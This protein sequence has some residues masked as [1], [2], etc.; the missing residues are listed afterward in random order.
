MKCVTPMLPEPTHT[1]LRCP[2]RASGAVEG[3]LLRPPGW[4][5]EALKRLLTI[6]PGPKAVTVQRREHSYFRGDAMADAASVAAVVTRPPIPAVSMSSP[7]KPTK[8]SVTTTTKLNLREYGFLSPREP[9]PLHTWDDA[10]P[11]KLDGTLQPPVPRC[12]PFP[13]GGGVLRTLGHRSQWP[14]TDTTT[15]RHV[16]MHTCLHPDPACGVYTSTRRLTRVLRSDP[17]AKTPCGAGCRPGCPCELSPALW[18]A[19][20]P[21][22]GPPSSARAPDTDVPR[23]LRSGGSRHGGQPP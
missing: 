15:G 12:Q 23:R 11:L 6:R 20:I 22:W 8:R 3:A 1:Q 16:Y 19:S 13:M 5:W 21:A 14:A 10:D 9:P 4:H 18:S 2:R 17:A 7:R